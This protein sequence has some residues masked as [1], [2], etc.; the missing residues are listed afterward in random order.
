MTFHFMFEQSGTF[1][2]EAK[3]LGYAAYD[4]DIKN[5][6]EE[7]DHIVDLFEQIETAFEGGYSVFDTISPEDIIIAFF[8]CVR[9]SEQNIINIRGN[10]C[11]MKNWTLEQKL[12]YG[13]E[14]CD[15]MAYFFKLV[16]KL[17]VVTL[18]KGLRLIIEN[19]YGEQHFLTR[20][21]CLQPKIIDHNRREN[22]DYYKKPTQYFFVNLEP[23]NNFL[24]EPIEWADPK[25]IEFTRNQVERSL[26]H[27]Q[28]ANRFLRRY[29]I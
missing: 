20:Y 9:F 18:R 26:I 1:K 27:P 17:V 28:Y 11:G 4:Y 14:K 12:I 6:F 24:F 16:S 3:K 21:W 23:K 15:E 25:R 7:T 10:N 5:D 19:P 22:G 29:V 8:P 2:N 13:F